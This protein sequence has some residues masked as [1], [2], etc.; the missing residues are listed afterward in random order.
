MNIIVS[1]MT[2]KRLYLAVALFAMSGILF[3][4]VC[5]QQ[6]Y[7]V[8]DI[9]A[10]LL[11][12]SSAVIR[13]NLKSVELISED[14]IT[15]SEK[16]VI[17]VLNKKGLAT[18][19]PWVGYDEDTFVKFVEAK[20]YDENGELTKEFREKDFQD[21]SATG[22]SL[23]SDSRLKFLD[24][25]P[26]FYPFTFEFKRVW[27]SS[28]TGFL[29]QWLPNPFTGVSAEHSKYI[30]K[31]PSK[32]PLEPRVYN[33]EGKKVES[34]VTAELISFEVRDLPAIEQEVLGPHYSEFLPMVRIAPSR[35]TLK[36]KRARVSDWNDFGLW[37]YSQLLNGRREL[38]QSTISRVNSLVLGIDDPKEKAR[39]IYEYMQ[40]K[41]RYVSVQIGI[42]GWQPSLASEV[43]KLGYGDCKG[44]TNYTMALLESQGIESYY[45][46]VDSG[47]NGQDIDEKFVALQG[48]HVILT[49]P[50]D[51]ENVFLE[52]TDQGLP[53]NYLGTHTDDRK[54]FA[55]TPEGGRMLKTH[56][57]SATTN[58]RSLDATIRL[59]EAFK[60]SGE[61]EQR[62]KGLRYYYRYEIEKETKDNIDSRIKEDWSHLNSL[63]LSEISFNNNK[64]KVVFAEK[65]M[66][67]TDDYVSEVGSRIL[68]NPN[69]FR[70][71]K[72]IPS[73]SAGRHQMLEIRRGYTDVD[74]ISWIL[75][76]NIDTESVF[77]PINY[78]TKFGNYTAE[79][80]EETGNKLTYRRTFT[81]NSGRYPAKEFNSFVDFVRMVARYDR[82]RIV[83]VKK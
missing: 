52:C 59:D 2:R 20:V 42:G 62:F 68:V 44:L 7:A 79:I 66:F 64:N 19:Q 12:N 46:I 56:K 58:E 18:L 53:F 9:P 8:A 60:L 22:S 5:A 14:Q 65:M 13:N 63:R 37:Q 55:V 75:P 45:T 25:T 11:Q 38:P 4:T 34:I 15:V 27:R 78:K 73:K 47:P 21:V 39:I 67:K 80:I 10:D 54:V 41:T 30:L 23:Y 81:L 29:P 43:D 35:F 36:G 51:D 49:L 76:P 24:F 40:S 69:V 26:A 83:L 48:D 33:L 31:N 6:K 16:I 71:I 61:I 74:Q 1:E 82:S 70:R 28:S 72:D 50:F 32:I 3:S 17:T 77:E 57:Y